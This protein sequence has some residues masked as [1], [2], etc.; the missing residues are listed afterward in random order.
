MHAAEIPLQAGFTGKERDVKTGYDYGVYPAEG[1]RR[2]PKSGSARY[3]DSRIGRWLSVDP[4]AENYPGWSPYAYSLDNPSRFVDP[5]GRVVDEFRV[6]RERGTIVKVSN[7]GASERDYYNV[8]KYNERGGSSTE[9][10]IVVH[11]GVG[12]INSFRFW[13]SS[14][15][16]ISA[17][18]IPENGVSGNIL[19]PPGPSTL[20]AGV[21]RRIP[22][23]EYHVMKN[24]GNK[25]PNVYKLF[26]DQ[27]RRERGILIHPG[28]WWY[29]TKG[30][31]LPGTGWK[32]D[33]I[34]G[35]T[36][37]PMV[38][39]IQNYINQVGVQNVEVHI[40]NII[41]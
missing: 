38:E 31:L 22:E 16:T 26:S 13:E 19:E 8:G 37:T 14:K 5:D 41:P 28:N 17:F 32:P 40:F 29:D 15:S 12:T 7:K 6:D 10:V 21:N 25:F 27:V 35:R 2:R 30:C 23:G 11:R 39:R 18:N 33:F 24:D 36:S 20:V 3:Y 34:L 4:M 1:R 9:Q